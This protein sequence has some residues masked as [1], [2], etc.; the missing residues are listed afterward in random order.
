M[1]HPKQVLTGLLWLGIAACGGSKSSPMLPTDSMFDEASAMS[2]SGTEV[3]SGASDGGSGSDGGSDGGSGDASGGSSDGGAGDGGS[4]DNGS[5]GS[6]GGSGG[7]DDGGT[8]DGGDLSLPL[9]D[10]SLDDLN[11]SSATYGQPV[12]PR[13]LLAQTSGWYFTHS[14]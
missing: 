12:S 13:D 5:S 11:P 4:G 14:T 2:D 1:N 7:T 10:F 6:D 9:P 8:D 3:D